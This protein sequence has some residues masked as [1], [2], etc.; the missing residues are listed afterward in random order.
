MLDDSS[1]EEGT[2]TELNKIMEAWDDGSSS[3]ESSSSDSGS[4]S[5][6][7]HTKNCIMDNKHFTSELLNPPP[8]LVQVAKRFSTEKPAF[9]LGKKKVKKQAG[10]KKT[11]AKTAKKSNGKKDSKKGKKKEKKDK[12]EKKEKKEKKASPKGNGRTQV[13]HRFF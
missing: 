8:F 4:S 12:K 7:L 1:V 5:R 9:N 2:E 6:S 13:V 11:K 10:T 3:S